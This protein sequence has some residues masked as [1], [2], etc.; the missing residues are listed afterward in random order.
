MRPRRIPSNQFG[1]VGQP[2]LSSEPEYAGSSGYA[3]FFGYRE[4][5][6]FAAVA[7]YS[8]RSGS[9]SRNTGLID[10]MTG[11]DRSCDSARAFEASGTSETSETC[12]A[13]GTGLRRGLRL[14]GWILA[15]VLGAFCLDTGGLSAEPFQA[16]SESVVQINVESVDFSYRDPWQAPSLQGSGGTGFIIEGNRIMTN[17]HVVSGA[18]QIRIKRPSQKK[19]YQARV[20]HIAHDC[21]LAI[22]TV[23]DPE[24]FS[25]ARPLEI[26]SQ[27]ALN[28]PVTV[29][30]FPIGGNRLSITRGVVSRIDMD[31]YSHSGVDAHRIIQVDAAINPG[32][33]G[34]P[35]IQDGKVIGVAFQAITSA[36]NLGYLI[37][38]V[39]VQ[40]FLKDIEDGSY[41]GYVEFGVLDSPIQNPSQIQA[42]EIKDRPSPYYGVQVYRIIPG[43][44]A[45]TGLKPGDVLISINGHRITGEGDVEIEGALYPYLELVDH[46]FEGDR[47]AV[48]YIRDG[49][50]GSVSLESKR[51][52]VLTFKRRTYGKAPEYYLL[53]GYLFQPLNANLMDALGRQWSSEGRVQLLYRYHYHLF[54]GL[55]QEG[56]VDVVLTR[57]LAHPVNAYG[58]RYLNQIVES[59]NGEDVLNFQHFVRL[60]QKNRKKGDVVIRFQDSEVPL[61]LDASNLKGQADAEIANRYG[62]PRLFRIE[63]KGENQ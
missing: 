37:P 12:R 44:T 28:T 32:N 25:G 23:E 14:S 60:L 5:S 40:R 34:G 31:V 11:R 16:I 35:A 48:E 36:E 17:A 58:D 62:I 13:S 21:D 59:V 27:P 63:S 49:K 55:Y 50:K 38:P 54:H 33:S 8:G 53:Q 41:E 7:A 18:V 20:A 10:L 1:L 42:L 9:I 52:D 2:G 43:S 57:R 45:A 6:G 3:G 61:V 56:G 15:F 46:V 39:V 24:F 47:I 51:S 26:G 19:D 22:L 30:G 29:L 4:C